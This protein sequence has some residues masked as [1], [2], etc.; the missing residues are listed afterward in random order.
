MNN[1]EFYGVLKLVSGEELFAKVSPCEEEY[2]TILILESPV[3]FE[4]I[5]M[6]NQAHGAVR[7]VPWVKMC[8]ETSFV[9]NMDKVIT[10]TE[11]KDKEVIKL[12]ERY[13]NDI[14]GGTKEQDFNR[15]LGF[16]P[17]IP[18]ARVILEKLYKKKNNS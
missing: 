13:L 2:R 12:Y 6:K 17:S 1:E 15:D 3:T 10:V 16:L 4:T 8:N 11:V 5:P 18:E 7:I 14:N 9:V